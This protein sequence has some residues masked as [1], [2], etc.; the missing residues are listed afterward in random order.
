[1]V[2]LT[3]RVVDF[4]AEEDGDLHIGLQDV[5]GDKPGVVVGQQHVDSALRKFRDPDDA[6]L[7]R[8]DLLGL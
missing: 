7:E 8:W 6:Y 2:S 4:R 3:G 1:M 5:I